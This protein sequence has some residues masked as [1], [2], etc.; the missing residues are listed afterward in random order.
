M[1]NV[2]TNEMILKG[3]YAKAQERINEILAE[4]GGNKAKAVFV[5]DR[6]KKLQHIADLIAR[7][8]N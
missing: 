5:M 8:E 6:D 3:L 4:Q 2:I 7:F 1:G